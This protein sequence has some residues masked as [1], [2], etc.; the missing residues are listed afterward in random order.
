[1]SI[2]LSI[3]NSSPIPGPEQIFDTEFKFHAF[4]FFCFSD[5]H[6]SVGMY[7]ST[8]MSSVIRMEAGGFAKAL[9][10]KLDTVLT[11]QKIAI[12]VFMA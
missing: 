3:T 1:M 9:F 4:I 12:T 7:E 11:I 10:S 6:F 2:H 8:H 5:G